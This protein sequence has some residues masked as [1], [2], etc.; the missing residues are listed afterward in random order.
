MWKIKYSWF[1]KLC[2]DKFPEAFR[3]F[4]KK[5]E[6]DYSKITDSNQLMKKFSYWQN[7]PVSPKQRMV[8]RQIAEKKGIPIIRYRP[9]RTKAQREKLRRH[10]TVVTIRGKSRVVARIPKGK[11]GAGRFAKRK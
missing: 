5:E 9:R 7:R 8:I 3:R 1:L 10:Y 2:P 11:K 6:I 4:E